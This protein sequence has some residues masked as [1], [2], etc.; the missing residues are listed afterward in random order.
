MEIIIIGKGPAGVSTALYTTRAGIKTTIIGRDFGAL[1]RADKVENYYGFAQPISATALIEA[2][3]AGVKRLGCEVI[4]DEV[5]GIGFNDKLSVKT[6]NRLYTADVVVLAT[7][8]VRNRPRIKGLPEFEG[9]GVSYCAICDAFFYR[10]KDVCVVGNGEYAKNEAMELLPIA[11][12]VTLL[13]NG[14]PLDVTLTDEIK[15]I[16]TPIREFLGERGLEKVVF[17]NNN[18]IEVTGAFIAVG[19]ASSSD[20]AKKIGAGLSGNN[21]AV[22]K[23]MMTN[24]PNLYAVGDC[25]GGLLQISK[26]VADG[27]IAGTAIVKSKNR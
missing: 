26:A 10:G 18:S 9:K 11:S 22:D 5:V 8:T 1:E 13:T 4:S 24:V 20:L 12:S 21:I 23:N 3:V 16:D 14:L 27:A 25:I 17:E 6:R 19:T 2:G 7:G 15:V